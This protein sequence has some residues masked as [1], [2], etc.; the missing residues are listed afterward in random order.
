M[1]I[2]LPTLCVGT[3]LVLTLIADRFSNGV[4]AVARAHG[5][6]ASERGSS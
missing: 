4:A 2:R 6:N 3:L 1:N 5:S